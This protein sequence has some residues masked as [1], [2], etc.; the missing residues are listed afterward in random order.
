MTGEV[1]H[2]QRSDRDAL[3]D[4]LADI[5]NDLLAAEMRGLAQHLDTASPYLSAR[6]YR[7]WAK[8]RPMAAVSRRHARRLTQ[9]LADLDL[10]IR[11]RSFDPAVAFSHYQS[12][13]SLLPL[14]IEQKRR[15]IADCQHAM[16]QRGLPPVVAAALA[17]I[18]RDNQAQLDVLLDVLRT[19]PT[20]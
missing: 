5:L 10:P 3:T 2:A 9:L 15:Q 13:D 1:N 8:L 18:L 6:T 16:K 17:S 12:L 7:A 19:M 11:P 14:L 20:A 4:A